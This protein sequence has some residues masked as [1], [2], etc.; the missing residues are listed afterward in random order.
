MVDWVKHQVLT[1]CIPVYCAEWPL[2]AGTVWRVEK[3]GPSGGFLRR[4]AWCSCA[5]TGAWGLQET[6]ESSKHLFFSFLFCC[7]CHSFS[8]RDA[9]SVSELLHWHYCH[10]Y[11]VGLVMSLL[12]AVNKKKNPF[13]F[14]FCCCYSLSIRV[15]KLQRFRLGM[16]LSLFLLVLVLLL[17]VLS[18][19][20]TVTVSYSF[21]PPESRKWSVYCSFLFFSCSSCW[22]L[23]HT[24]TLV[25]ATTVLVFC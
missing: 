25:G 7:C 19:I 10:F 8:V 3:G 6:P 12:K 18:V 24:F 9:D 17:V 15:F 14:L 2:W 1:Y 16:T 11:S 20:V 4:A 5:N 21:V 22:S 13:S 23:C